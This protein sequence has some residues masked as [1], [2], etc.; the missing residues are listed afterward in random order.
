MR[1]LPIYALNAALVALVATV[2][3]WQ[4]SSLLD[5]AMDVYAVAFLPIVVAILISGNAHAPS[6]FGL[7]L[8]VF[9]DWLIICLAV[10]AVLWGIN[11]KRSK[12]AT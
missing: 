4:F 8:G 12:V 6:E 9:L 5:Q 7:Y 1:P 3:S 2:L 11:R 10:A